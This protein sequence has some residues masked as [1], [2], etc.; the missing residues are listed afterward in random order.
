MSDHDFDAALAALVAVRAAS[1]T[2]VDHARAATDECAAALVA[3]A[4]AKVTARKA[5]RITTS[6]HAFRV[7]GEDEHRA[8]VEPRQKAWDA[9]VAA[10]DVAIKEAKEALKAAAV[11]AAFGA[12]APEWALFRR[13]YVSSYSTQGFGAGHYAKSC[14]ED[15]ADHA[16]HH[17]VEVEVRREG[18]DTR[19][20]ECFAVYV[21]LGP[22][23][24]ALLEQ[25]PGP[26]LR[27]W[28]KACWKRGA[29]PRVLN[30]FLPH[31]LEERLGIDYF[32]N[33]VA[34]RGGTP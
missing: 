32:G 15:H 9:R 26:S 28:L 4:R 8:I 16:R 3:A 20:S 1:T 25:K 18:G 12:P 2:T 30:P 6:E 22:R 11:D 13:V 5:A 17:G 19:G 21:K 7:L 23:D 10:E 31:G 24:L 14:A 29:N 33:D 27:D 34:P